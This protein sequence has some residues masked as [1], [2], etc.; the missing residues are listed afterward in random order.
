VTG[1]KSM[2]F[3]ICSLPQILGL[4]NKGGMGRRDDKW[5]QISVEELEGKYNFKTK[6]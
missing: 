5:T 2:N 3:V 4:S 1:V 6:A